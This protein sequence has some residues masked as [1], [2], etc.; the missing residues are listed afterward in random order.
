MAFERGARARAFDRV[1]LATGSKPDCAGVPL[2]KDA[3]DT[4][5]LPV[6]RGFPALADDLTWG[7]ER[8]PWRAAPRRPSRNRPTPRASCPSTPVEALT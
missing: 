8:R 6:A 7:E 1:I 2:F 4:F 5:G 3:V